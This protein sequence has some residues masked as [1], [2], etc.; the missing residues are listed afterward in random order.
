[1]SGQS[2]LGAKTYVVPSNSNNTA[3]QGNALAT[4]F[5]LSGLS[6]YLFVLDYHLFNPIFY[7][8]NLWLIIIFLL[9][10]S[11]PITINRKTVKKNIALKHSLIALYTFLFGTMVIL[12]LMYLHGVV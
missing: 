6:S 1:M 11:V 2:V 10:I 12:Y 9:V 4:N 7:K 3:L 8:I 5:Y